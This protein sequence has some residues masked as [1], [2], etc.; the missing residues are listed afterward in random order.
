M[1]MRLVLWR[2]VWIEFGGR[3]FCGSYA[4]EDDGLLTVRTPFGS[5][6]TQFSGSSAISIARILLKEL[7]ADGHAKA[8]PG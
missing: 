8:A 3:S 2:R 6:A 1:A 4:V 7:A 5:K